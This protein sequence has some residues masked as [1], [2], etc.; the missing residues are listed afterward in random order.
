MK[1]YVLTVSKTFPVTHPRKGEPTDFAQKIMAFHKIH[2]IRDNVELWSK[3][4]KE[5][6]EGRAIISARQWTGKPYGSKQIEF[7]T[8]ERI[9]IQ[10]IELTMLGFF[11]DT[12]E[13]DVSVEVLAAFDGLSREDF[14]A[15]FKDGWKQDIPKAIIHFT[16]F[17]Y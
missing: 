12:I 5:V 17:R 11:I 8:Y 3:R 14:V 4:A 7:A 13:S 6:N 2:T 1:T 9:G 15:W 10:V 16:D